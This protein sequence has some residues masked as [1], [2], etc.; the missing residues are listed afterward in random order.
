[1]QLPLLL[2]QL[3]SIGNAACGDIESNFSNGRA[4]RELS[5]LKPSR[6]RKLPSEP[7]NTWIR[8]HWSLVPDECNESAKVRDMDPRVWTGSPVVLYVRE[9]A[10]PSDGKGNRFIELY[11]PNKRNCKI[12]CHG[13]REGNDDDNPTAAPSFQPSTYQL[14]IGEKRGKKKKHLFPSQAKELTRM[15]T[16][17]F[18]RKA[19]GMV[20]VERL[21]LLVPKKSN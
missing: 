10:D 18:V 17:S 1:L 9:L 12:P 15:D 6:E 16:W 5:A 2:F 13:G 4:V 21:Y 7:S 8:E 20:G 19:L 3:Q 11:S 14:V